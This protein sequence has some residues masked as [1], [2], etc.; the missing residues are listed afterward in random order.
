M[1]KVRIKVEHAISGIMRSRIMKDVYGITND[2]F[3]DPGMIIA[4]GLLN[5][6]IGIAR[7]LRNHD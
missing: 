2:G 5:F 4:C 6:R 3:S 7:N 1:S